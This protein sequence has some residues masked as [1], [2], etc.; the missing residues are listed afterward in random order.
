MLVTWLGDNHL[1]L[2][3]NF[4]PYEIIRTDMCVKTVVMV[5]WSFDINKY[6]DLW[7]IISAGMVMLLSNANYV[8]HYNIALL[9]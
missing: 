5:V 2:L 1:L 7:D 4:G 6:C 3:R 8:R 9:S